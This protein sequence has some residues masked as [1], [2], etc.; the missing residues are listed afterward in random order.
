MAQEVLSKHGSTTSGRPYI[1]SMFAWDRDEAFVRLNDSHPGFAKSK[2][3]I[4]RLMNSVKN[5]DSV[6]KAALFQSVR[7]G[8]VSFTACQATVQEFETKLTV[9]RLCEGADFWDEFAR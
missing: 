1:Y 6:S 3:M 2:K 4:I 8:L 9:L 7:P 5:L